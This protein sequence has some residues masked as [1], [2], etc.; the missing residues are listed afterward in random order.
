MLD[1]D[2]GQRRADPP[3]ECKWSLVLQYVPGPG[4]S[5]TFPDPGRLV[6]LSLRLE[7][8]RPTD[9]AGGVLVCARPADGG[10]ARGPCART[11]TCR[12]AVGGSNV[13]VRLHTTPT[14]RAGLAPVRHASAPR[15]VPP[16]AVQ[17]RD[18]ANRP[19]PCQ[20]CTSDRKPLVGRMHDRLAR[21]HIGCRARA[22]G[23]DVPN[24][25]AQPPAGCH[26]TCCTRCPCT[27]R[28]PLHR[29]QG[30]APIMGA[31]SVDPSPAR[32]WRHRPPRGP[33]PCSSARVPRH[34]R[35]CGG[36]TCHRGAR[37]GSLGSATRGPS[38]ASTRC[39]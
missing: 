33:R 18:A 36:R 29:Q 6:P 32:A 3:T 30:L 23:G 2:R 27:G 7:G 16:Q 15:A 39:L 20:G 17:R 22:A 14:T 11:P 4:T 10:C 9:P 8:P 37:V 28:G 21:R 13:R 19:L 34:P 1:S 38:G 24:M 12:P 31:V 5:T 35:G 26:A 25:R